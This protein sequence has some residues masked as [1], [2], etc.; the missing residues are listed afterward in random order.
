MFG[1][2]LV[3]MGLFYG[4]PLGIERIQVAKTA[5]QP[6]L[7]NYA[8]KAHYVEGWTI[9]W[10]R[11]QYWI[12]DKEISG[13]IGL[14]ETVYTEV[15]KPINVV[16]INNPTILM[17]PNGEVFVNPMTKTI[18]FDPH[19]GPAFLD[20]SNDFQAGITFPNENMSFLFKRDG[21]TI[22]MNYNLAPR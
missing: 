17:T 11:N 21:R 10:A 12:L 15:K 7:P 8:Y 4:I 13:V 3:L 14:K 5:T 2:W 1:V 16:Q 22:V 6:E 19:F 18:I 20:E 9:A